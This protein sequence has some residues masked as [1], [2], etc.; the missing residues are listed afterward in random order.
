MNL[1]PFA[2]R[3]PLILAGLAP[4]LLA[5]TTFVVSTTSDIGSI[6]PDLP[7][8]EDGDLLIAAENQPVRPFLTAAHWSG[9][10]DLIPTD[11][12]ALGF[13]KNH[14]SWSHAMLFSLLSDQAGF[15]DGD[16]LGLLPGGGVEVVIA[17]AD[18]QAA[19][20]TTDGI[21]VDGLDVDSA[22]RLV[23]SLQNDLPLSP[24]GSINNGDLLRLEPGGSVVRLAT[25][26]DVQDALQIAAGSGAALGDV[27]G[28]ALLPGDEM[29]VCIQSPSAFDGGI[30]RIGSAPTLLA[31]ELALGLGGSELDAIATAPGDQTP[32][33]VWVELGAV[34]GS[35]RA[36]LEGQP[37]E[38]VAVIAAGTSGYLDASFFPG[39]G[40]FYVEPGDP[41]LSAQLFGPGLVLVVLDG[42]GRAETQI[43]LPAA[44]AGLGFDGNSGWSIQLLS[45]ASAELSAPVRVD[46]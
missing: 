44:G 14:P 12:D 2:L 42:T 41:A 16:I 34:A 15:R 29:A 24:L 45:L 36:V 22:G 6:S 25:E 38:V 19:L 9:V 1:L 8:L 10:G 3:A 39:F 23:F 30:L 46:V 33:T 11:I 32:L 18:L 31:D 43:A 37:G 21:D 13:V 40:A 28:V 35:G 5:Q 20:G 4:S 27:H 26:A 17:E 7:F